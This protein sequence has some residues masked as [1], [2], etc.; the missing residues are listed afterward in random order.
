MVAIDLTQPIDTPMEKKAR[1]EVFS[2]LAD[3][4]THAKK[5]GRAGKK[6]TRKEMSPLQRKTWDLFLEFTKLSLTS[7]HQS[8]SRQVR[9]KY[10]DFLQE[11]SRHAQKVNALVAKL[12]EKINGTAQQGKNSGE[13]YALRFLLRA[14]YLM[15][16]LR[17]DVI[18]SGGELTSKNRR[19]LRTLIEDSLQKLKAIG[20]FEKTASVQQGEIKKLD[21]VERAMLNYIEKARGENPVLENIAKNLKSQTLRSAYHRYVENSRDEAEAQYYRQLRKRLIEE[22]GKPNR[23]EIAYRR[24]KYL[25]K[26]L[27]GEVYMQHRELKKKAATA[28]RGGI[29]VDMALR[30]LKE[31]GF[32][33]GPGRMDGEN[34]TTDDGLARLL[35]EYLSAC[36]THDHPILNLNREFTDLELSKLYEKHQKEMSQAE[37]NAAKKFKASLLKQI[38][39]AR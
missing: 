11:D 29:S 23:S 30:H 31:A 1:K 32:F 26:R 37:R 17:K 20:A 33:D 36:R 14:R 27:K 38:R 5:L 28:R 19:E 18:Q 10:R 39:A 4:L 34:L 35:A 9:D 6:V 16:F 13:A 3:T 2:E 24:A 22:V 15:S 8:W 12:D 25:A 21:S 7:G